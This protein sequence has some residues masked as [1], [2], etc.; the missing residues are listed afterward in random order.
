[1]MMLHNI[2]LFYRGG[3]CA[4]SIELPQRLETHTFV[5]ICLPGHYNCRI[6]YLS[7]HRHSR[8]AMMVWLNFPWM[9]DTLNLNL[10]P[11]PVPGLCAYVLLTFWSENLFSKAGLCLIKPDT[12]PAFRFKH[13]VDRRKMNEH[14]VLSGKP[15]I[16][17]GILLENMASRFSSFIL[18]HQHQSCSGSSLSFSLLLRICFSLSSSSSSSTSSNTFTS[19]VVP[20]L[21]LLLPWPSAISLLKYGWKGIVMMCCYDGVHDHDRAHVAVVTA[22]EL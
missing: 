3:F 11:T 18:S 8:R 4:V 21:L 10:K 12:Y 15:S 9:Q 19:R 5:K 1:M 14:H 20:F 13:W 16:T 6:K 22:A 17:A 7:V 2:I